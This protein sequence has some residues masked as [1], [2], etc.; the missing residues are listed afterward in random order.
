M[1]CYDWDADG[2]HDLIGEFTTS[3]AQLMTQVGAGPSE[4]KWECIN[5]KKT[6]KR[7]YKNSGVVKLLSIKV[8]ILCNDNC[9]TTKF[10]KDLCFIRVYHQ[11]NIP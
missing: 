8:H 3:L 6:T 5:P 10:S 4:L 1:T 7:K 11:C 9:G 2:S